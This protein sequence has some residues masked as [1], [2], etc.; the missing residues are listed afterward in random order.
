MK[1]TQK[2][3][4]YRG[5]YRRKSANLAQQHVSSTPLCAAGSVVTA[6]ICRCLSDL[7]SPPSGFEDAGFDKRKWTTYVLLGSTLVGTGI[8][9][10]SD[11][12]QF[13]LLFI[14]RPHTPIQ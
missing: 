3:K 2:K 12:S 8:Y 9:M 14:P 1:I 4:L 5:T 13:P 6:P 10:V 7:R 11:R